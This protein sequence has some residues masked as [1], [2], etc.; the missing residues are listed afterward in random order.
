MPAPSDLAVPED[1][2]HQKLAVPEGQIGNTN[3]YS[4]THAHSMDARRTGCSGVHHFR[5]AGL[6]QDRGVQA[7]HAHRSRR[8]VGGVDG[9]NVSQPVEFVHLMQMDTRMSESADEALALLIV[10]GTALFFLALAGL[11]A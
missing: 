5:G 10:L 4:N 1:Q 7:Q 8:A 6:G 11:F 3:G 2:I 9:A